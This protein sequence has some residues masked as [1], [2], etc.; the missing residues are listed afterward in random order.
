MKLAF[1]SRT[2]GERQLMVPIKY[3]VSSLQAGLSFED[4]KHTLIQ[5]IKSQISCPDVEQFCIGKTFVCQS[6][7]SEEGIK[8]RWY[9]KYRN[10]GYDVMV[11]IAVISAEILPDHRQSKECIEQYTLSLEQELINYFMWSENEQR[12][13]N[14]TTDPGGKSTEDKEAYALYIAIKR[15]PTASSLNFCSA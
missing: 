9:R 15:S 4:I 3:Y 13:A 5:N 12:L 11:V 2:E 14:T 8:S 10:E 1:I 6:G 7:W